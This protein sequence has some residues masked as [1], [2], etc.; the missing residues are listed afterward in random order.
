MK[1]IIS[2]AKKMRDE[3]EGIDALTTP[4]FLQ[5]SKQLAAYIKRLS[6][7]ELKGLLTCN[8][9]L[10]ALN[11]RRYQQMDL[12]GR[13]EPALLVYDGIQYQY[14]APAVFEED[15]LA[16]A[17]AHLRILSGLYGVLKPLDGVVP[18]RLEMQAKLQ[19]PFCQNLYDFWGG[20]LYEEI[21]RE[22]DVILNLAS[23][24]YS[25]AIARYVKAPKRMV[26]AVFLQKGAD[27]SLKEKSVYVK[28]ARGEMVRYLCEQGVT[29]IEDIRYFDRSG[30]RYDKALSK[31]ERY[32]F[33]R[34][35]GEQAC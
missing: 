11:Y 17:Q 16:Y 7:A 10:N 12:S 4:I 24:E 29:R 3:A 32:V 26:D 28:M 30:Y 35:E 23:K 19:T 27:G 5:Q 14:M 25:R 22:D 31:E 1:I 15:A 18:Y 2:P 9:A 34:Q 13:G 21:T 6:P 20:A 8:D 33:V